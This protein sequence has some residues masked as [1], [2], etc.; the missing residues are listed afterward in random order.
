M[1]KARDWKINGNQ[2]SY[3]HIY[4]NKKRTKERKIQIIII[5]MLIKSMRDNEGYV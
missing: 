1:S 4:K 5:I 2:K 3:R